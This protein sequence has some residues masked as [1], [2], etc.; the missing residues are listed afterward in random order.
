MRGGGI[1]SGEGG[2]STS[3]LKDKNMEGVYVS[4]MSRL[5]YYYMKKPFRHR[6]EGVS[7]YLKDR[8]V[9]K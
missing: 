1:G 7:L 8:S 3:N 2:T 5:T 4:F 6:A 9:D